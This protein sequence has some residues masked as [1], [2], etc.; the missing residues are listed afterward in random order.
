LVGSNTQ[1]KDDYDALLSKI[2]RDS[3]LI[4]SELRKFLDSICASSDDFEKFNVRGKV[5]SNSLS[6]LKEI[7]K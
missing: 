2:K 4:N 1:R 5:H 7:I 6:E 3:I